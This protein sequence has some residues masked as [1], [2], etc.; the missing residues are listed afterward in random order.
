MKHY[1]CTVCGFIY[2][3]ENAE[4]DHEG[5]IIEFLDLPPEWNCPNCGV[6]PDLFEEANEDEP[7]EEL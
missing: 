2:K 3:E 6:S 5:K 1:S 7:S 4:K